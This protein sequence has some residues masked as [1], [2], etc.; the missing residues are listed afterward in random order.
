[1]FSFTIA[2]IPSAAS[3]TEASPIASAI[4]CTA[5]ARRLD[6]ERHLAAEQLRRQVPEHDVRVGHRWQLTAPAVGRRARRGAR[7]LRPD[8]E[9]LRQ[10]RDVGDRPAAR[11]DGVD[12]DRRDA[13]AEVRDRR[14]A[15]DRRL[16]VL[17]E[18][19]VGGRPSHVEGE[20]VVE[21]G[22]ARDEERA[23][24]AARRPREHRVDR[25]PRRLARRHQACVRAEDVDVRLRADR[26]QL[27]LE[28]ARRSRRPSVGRTSSCTRSAPART[29]GTPAGRARS[30]SP[31]SLDRGARRRAPICS[32]CAGLTYELTSATVSDSMPEPTRSR[33]ISSTCASSTGTTTLPRASRRSTASRVSARDAGGSGLIM[34][35]QPASGPGVCERARWRIWP[36]PLGR[37]QADARALRL[38]HRVRRHG[39]AVEDV[40]ELADADAGLVADPAD[41]GEHALGGIVGRRRRLDAELGAA[42]ALGHEEEVGE[43]TADV[44]PQPVR[45][46][47]SF[48]LAG[49]RSER[50]GLVD[51]TLELAPEL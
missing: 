43:G 19:D 38:E 48:R 2:R 32:S 9:R 49:D 3:S 31:G 7:R 45:H 46:V 11:T 23:G 28:A 27:G 20:D 30:A 26:L 21:A 18:G 5:V 36:K 51:L 42:V 16:P 41:A 8:A 39:G 37:D 15:A 13:D 47:V 1:M 6:V 44:D 14:L 34:M 17:A 25:V 10:L 35:I 33:T 40:L 22:L 4:V 50:A 24:D 12:V 29:P